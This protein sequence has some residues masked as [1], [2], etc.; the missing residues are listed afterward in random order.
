VHSTVYALEF[1]S[2]LSASALS[3][4]SSIFPDYVT[5]G[6]SATAL[7]TLGLTIEGNQIQGCSGATAIT[8]RDLSLGTGFWF[9][10]VNI[11]DNVVATDISFVQTYA[12][13]FEDCANINIERNFLG[14]GGDVIFCDETAQDVNIVENTFNS[15]QS[16]ASDDILFNSFAPTN[17]VVRGNTFINYPRQGAFNVNF[18]AGV[19]G[20]AIIDN[21]GMKPTAP[22]FST[23][24]TDYVLRNTKLKRLT[25]AP[26]SGNWALGD[27]VYGVPATGTPQ[28]WDC[29]SYGS[30]GTALAGVTFSGTIGAFTGTVTAGVG[31]L[32]VGMGISIAGANQQ[33]ILTLNAGTGVIT[34]H[35]Q[36]SATVA[37]AAVSLLPPTFHA[38]ANFV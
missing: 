34:F 21:I 27:V 29:T 12:I 14:Y 8:L 22:V 19:N 2:G 11:N 4:Y 10:Y 23:A 26:A 9:Q 1:V 36:L 13:K 15:V 16:T 35:Q 17:V 32:S 38:A 37:N 28:E 5:A 6:Y 25:A 18:V 33:C 31:Q 24:A 7:P 30:L 3:T 20:A